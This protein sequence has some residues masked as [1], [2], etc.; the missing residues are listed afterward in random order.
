MFEVTEQPTRAG[1]ACPPQM[2]AL[3]GLLVRPSQSVRVPLSKFVVGCPPFAIALTSTL[4]D[5]ET[6]RSRAN[7]MDVWFCLT[8]TPPSVP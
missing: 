3:T 5:H 6:R 2:S 4:L 1:F 7:Q 8:D